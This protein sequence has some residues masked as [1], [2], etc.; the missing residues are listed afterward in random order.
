MGRRG[1]GAP[2]AS[3]AAP[4]GRLLLAPLLLAPLLLVRGV[5]AT[6]RSLCGPVSHRDRIRDPRSCLPFRLRPALPRALSGLVGRELVRRAG[7]GR[8][9]QAGAVHDAV[10]IVQRRQLF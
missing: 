3:A 5:P 8:V 7:L 9:P 4:R 10:D 1:C 2:R 6:R